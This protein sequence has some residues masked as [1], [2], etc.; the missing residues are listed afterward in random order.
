MFEI[1]ENPFDKY[2]VAMYSW[3]L[4]ITFSREPQKQKM[5][6]NKNAISA[7]CTHNSKHVPV[8]LGYRECCMTSQHIQRSN[9]YNLK[10][11]GHLKQQMTNE[12]LWK[13]I[14]SLTCQLHKNC[15]HQHLQQ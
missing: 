2:W 15:H 9:A 14:I 13:L 11:V 12:I 1:C 4:V 6:C 7:T 10:T 5:G 8:Y 3:T